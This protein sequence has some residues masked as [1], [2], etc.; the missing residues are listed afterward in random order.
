MTSS[1]KKKQSEIIFIN[2]YRYINSRKNY[3]RRN[4]PRYLRANKKYMKDYDENKESSYLKYQ[5]VNS[6]YGLT[7]YQ[8]FS[9]NDFKQV[10]DISEFDEIFMKSCNEES[11]EIYFL[12]VDTQYLENYIIFTMIYLFT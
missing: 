8:K 1:P 7:M 9:V 2:G 11:D 3:Q 5:Y 10:E 6:L 12:E 4:I